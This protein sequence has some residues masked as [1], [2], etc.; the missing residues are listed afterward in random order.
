MGNMCP[1][2]RQKIKQFHEKKKIESTVTK[3]H[4]NVATQTNTFTSKLRV[5]K[6]RT[7]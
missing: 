7:V 5:R 3:G 2:R 1:R 4:Q 6:S